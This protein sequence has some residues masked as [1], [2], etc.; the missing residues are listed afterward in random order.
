LEASQLHQ[1]TRKH[2][3]QWGNDWNYLKYDEVPGLLSDF[4]KVELKTVGFFAAFGRSEWQRRR[5]A[6]LDQLIH[7]AIPQSKRY[8]ILVRASKPIIS[9]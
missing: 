6:H 8:I 7:F 9:P 1:Y 5:L 2:F 3:I 4:E